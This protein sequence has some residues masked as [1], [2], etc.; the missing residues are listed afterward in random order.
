MAR[1]VGA[2]RMEIT[3]NGR[4]GDK[5]RLKTGPD[6]D[7]CKALSLRGTSG[8]VAVWRK[9]IWKLPATGRFTMRYDRCYTK[10]FERVQLVKVRLRPIPIDGRAVRLGQNKLGYADVLRNHA[11]GPLSCRVLLRSGFAG[12]G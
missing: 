10:A 2:T 9:D 5:V 7:N 12:R 3:F 11:P 8:K 4:K 6:P 1:G